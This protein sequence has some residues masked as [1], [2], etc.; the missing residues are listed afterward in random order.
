MALVTLSKNSSF[1]LRSPS[2]Q[3]YLQHAARALYR[4]VPHPIPKMGDIDGLKFVKLLE[5]VPP[6]GTIPIVHQTVYLLAL[7]E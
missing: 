5:D 3:T 6:S 4:P 1:N 2:F 7:S